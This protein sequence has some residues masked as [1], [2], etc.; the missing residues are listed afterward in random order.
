MGLLGR[1]DQGARGDY[2]LGDELLRTLCSGAKDP[3]VVSVKD[4]YHFGTTHVYSAED[5]VEPS[6]ER[7][8]LENQRLA[9]GQSCQ[10]QA[11]AKVV[12]SGQGSKSSELPE[13]MIIGVKKVP[14]IVLSD[15]ED[16]E[17]YVGSVEVWDEVENGG[18]EDSVIYI[19]DMLDLEDAMEHG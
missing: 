5:D 14:V 10:E 4:H 1:S 3:A 17:Q 8:R 7:V 19:G 2:K 16:E 18:E 9:I 13:M 11:A 12:S 15:W 6:D